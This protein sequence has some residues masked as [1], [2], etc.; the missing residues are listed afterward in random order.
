MKKLI[1]LA[2]LSSFTFSCK[3]EKTM[4]TVTVKKQINQDSIDKV[5]EQEVIN[6]NV[7]DSKTFD[8][9]LTDEKSKK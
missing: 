9:V 4:N 2:F 3:K 1:I 7:D 5:R 8:K 6:L